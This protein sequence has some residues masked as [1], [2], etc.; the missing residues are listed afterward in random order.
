MGLAA[1][2]AL[3][4]PRYSP[5][6]RGIRWFAGLR[7]GDW[8]L[9]PTLPH[10]DRWML[11]VSGGRRTISEM[12]AGVPTLFLTTTGARSGQQRT[13][14][15][16]GVPIGDDLAVI[17]SNFG[18]RAD[19][20]WVINVIADPRATASCHGRSAQVIVRELTGAQAEQVWAAGRTLYRGFATYPGMVANRTIRVFRLELVNP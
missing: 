12:L 9:A 6:A 5:L 8:L 7:V 11:R 20:G 2:L 18:R 13:V 10:L 16:I 17:G 15:L 14:Q 3:S 19:P 4:S 1:E